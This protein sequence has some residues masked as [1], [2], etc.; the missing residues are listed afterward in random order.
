MNTKNVFFEVANE[1]MMNIDGGTVLTGD[2]V[3]PPD[4]K[5]NWVYAST[6][7]LGVKA[8]INKSVS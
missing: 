1:E 6:V 3:A 2:C 7:A 8:G 5:F 4:I